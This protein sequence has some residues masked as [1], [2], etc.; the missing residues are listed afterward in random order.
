[1]TQ[2]V[3]E[4]TDQVLNDYA[5]S[6]KG[7]Q[8]LA[9][10]AT[11]FR[12]AHASEIAALTSTISSQTSE[13][14]H[15]A[16]AVQL[17]EDEREILME[18]IVRLMQEREMERRTRMR[19][20]SEVKKTSAG[21]EMDSID[22]NSE[23]SALREQVAMQARTIQTLSQSIAKL[24]GEKEKCQ[25]ECESLRREVERLRQQHHG[26]NRIHTT[27]GAHPSD[28]DYF[29]HHPSSPRALQHSRDLH[30]YDSRPAP[31]HSHDRSS[32]HH[33]THSHSAHHHHSRHPSRHHHRPHHSHMSAS[34]PYHDHDHDRHHSRV[35]SRSHSR[36]RV[37]SLHSHAH[38]H[39]HAHE[40]QNHQHNRATSI[41]YS[42]SNTSSNSSGNEQS[43]GTERYDSISSSPRHH[44][45]SS[46]EQ[47][48]RQDGQ[49]SNAQL[50]SSTLP[51]T[52]ARSPLPS[53]SPAST[54]ASPGAVNMSASRSPGGMSIAAH[55]YDQTASAVHI[56]YRDSTDGENLMQPHKHEQ[57][58][59]DDDDDHDGHEGMMSTMQAHSSASNGAQGFRTDSEGEDAAG[60]E[61]ERGHCDMTDAIADAQ[62]R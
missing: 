6:M 46:D 31:S 26:D 4:F 10:L 16:A 28:V 20:E 57:D 40:P 59:D 50:S 24:Q 62:P 56:E 51:A 5:M 42:N 12:A 19:L 17:G 60:H 49:E 30:G 29:S 2:G 47:R 52:M 35:Y 39:A 18:T 23:M 36:D 14:N 7:E 25:A 61:H 44:R 8:D 55:V 38:A 41:D 45:Y 32:S 27:L 48:R 34:S 3:Q 11:Q 54:L 1:M 15:A 22:D 13:L 37:S 33:S 9:S 43:I 58:H 21:K 53:P